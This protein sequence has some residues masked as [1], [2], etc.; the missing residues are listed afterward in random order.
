M[1][2]DLVVWMVADSAD[3]RVVM[4]AVGSVVRLADQKA[5]MMVS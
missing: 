4:K 5:E 1:V 3:Q 2:A